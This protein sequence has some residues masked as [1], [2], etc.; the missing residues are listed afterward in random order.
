MNDEDFIRK[1]DK[2]PGCSSSERFYESLLREVQDRGLVD[3]EVSCFD[4]QLQQGAALPAQK[5]TLLP[6]GSE[7]P[8]F[9]RIWDTCCNCGMVYSTIL[10]RTK[11][12]KSLEVAPPQLNRA[13]RRRMEKLNPDLNKLSLS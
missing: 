2:C 5:V 4:F 1:F 3:K 8:A 6:F 13:E 7:I 9:K 12:K 11:V 10:E